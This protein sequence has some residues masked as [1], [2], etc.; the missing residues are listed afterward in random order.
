[1]L[2]LSLEIFAHF[3]IAHGSELNV[4]PLHNQAS[5]AESIGGPVLIALAAAA[6]D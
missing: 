1:M 6:P 5:G 3:P 2:P 4:K